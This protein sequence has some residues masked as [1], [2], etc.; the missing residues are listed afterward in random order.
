MEELIAVIA[1][2]LVDNPDQVKVSS[3]EEDDNVT[4]ELSVAAE[5][6]D[7]LL[8]LA[9]EEAVDLTIVGPEAPLAFERQMGSGATIEL[10]GK[11]A[12]SHP[13]RTLEH[14][15]ERHR[16]DR[17]LAA[18]PGRALRRRRPGGGRGGRRSG[19]AALDPDHLH[20][21]RGLLPGGGRHHSGRGGI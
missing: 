18:R 14:P 6:L 9:Q 3:T 17:R 2:S 4:I 10:G 13:H 16:R 20:L 21:G 11:R 19:G 15:A 7:A 5:D 12:G 1:R 8:A